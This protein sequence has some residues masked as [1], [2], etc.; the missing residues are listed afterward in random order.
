M[1]DEVKKVK[2]KENLYQAK[3]LGSGTF[4]ITKPK[5]KPK[6]LRQSRVKKPQRQ[7]RK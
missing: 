5:R 1:A 7:A 3:N 4:S 6:K 2:E